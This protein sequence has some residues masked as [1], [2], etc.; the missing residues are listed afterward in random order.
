PPVIGFFAKEEMYLA[1]TA[2]GWLSVAIVAV[3]LLGNAALAAVA[4]AVTLRPF[5]GPVVGTPKSPHEAGL[6]MLAG[7][8]AFGAAG[9]AVAFTTAWLAGMLVGPATSAVLGAAVEAHLELG[10]DLTGIVF[11]LSVVTWVLA[12]ILFWQLDRT[13]VFL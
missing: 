2:G 13:R 8:A 12:G 9:I 4:L 5:M 7:P 10:I 3:L 1:A 6:G 11:W